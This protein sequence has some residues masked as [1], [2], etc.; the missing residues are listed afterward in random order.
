MLI[1][2]HDPMSPFS[3]M[4]RAVLGFKR[5]A[6]Q[7]VIIPTI[8]PKPDLLEATH[9]YYT[10]RREDARAGVVRVHFPRIGYALRQ[11]TSS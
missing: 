8:M 2:H 11:E 3:E 4:I 6:W 10:L 5:L 9:H 7:S 1:L